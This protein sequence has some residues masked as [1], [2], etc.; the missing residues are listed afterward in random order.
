MIICITIVYDDLVSKFISFYNIVITSKV[1]QNT[2]KLG[3]EK[4]IGD[5]D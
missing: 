2:D 1:R 5:A 4:K 3:I